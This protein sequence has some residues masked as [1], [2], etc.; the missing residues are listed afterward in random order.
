VSTQ[1]LEC[2]EATFDAHRSWC[3]K[4][5]QPAINCQLRFS[6]DQTNVF[7]LCAL[8]DSAY[9]MGNPGTFHFRSLIEAVSNGVFE[10]GGKPGVFTVSD[11]CDFIKAEG[12]VV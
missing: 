10:A 11:I 1:N 5:N 12:C 3:G 2:D 8:V 6:F 7:L 9:G 4:L